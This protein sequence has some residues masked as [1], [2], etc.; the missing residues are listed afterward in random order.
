MSKK[1]TKLALSNLND[2][3]VG[4]SYTCNIHVLMVVEKILL[5]ISVLKKNSK[6]GLGYKVVIL[7]IHV[8]V[9]IV[10]FYILGK[11]KG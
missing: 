8:C 9:L 1:P 4:P 7:C 11:V 3:T 10:C 2:S 5:V 6:I